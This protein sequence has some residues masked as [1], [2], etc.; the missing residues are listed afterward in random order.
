LGA[1]GQSNIQETKT[2]QY[3][4]QSVHAIFQPTNDSRI[5]EVTVVLPK[6]FIFSLLQDQGGVRKSLVQEEIKQTV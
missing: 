5:K 4:F 6:L 2:M 3:S 1:I